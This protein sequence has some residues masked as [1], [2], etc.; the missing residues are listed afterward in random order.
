MHVD[1]RP[2]PTPTPIHG[3]RTGSARHGHV[4]HT[5]STDMDVLLVDERCWYGI[6]PKNVIARLVAN[7]CLRR[8]A[9]MRMSRREEHLFDAAV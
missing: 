2:S 7:H 3:L 1:P 4:E 8:L 5:T 9:Y 6:A